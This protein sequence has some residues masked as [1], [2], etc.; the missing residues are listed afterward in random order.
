[1]YPHE[2][3]LVK[4]M[5]NQ[6]FA[7]I[8]VNSDSKDRALEAMERENITW[9]SFFNGG[10]T[11]GPISG[12]WGVRSWPTIYVMDQRGVI[13][14]KNVR[15]E[16][17]TEA[18]EELVKEA[19]AALVDDLKSDQPAVR[20]IAAF[21][22]GKYNLPNALA[23]IKPLLKD[24]DPQVQQ[25][26]AVGLVL[27]QQSADDLRPLIRKAV[28]DTDTEVRLAALETLATMKDAQA[29]KLA[30]K[31]LE[32]PQITVRRTAVL[33]LGKI[34]DPAAVPALAKAVDDTDVITARNAAYA[35]A[36]I[37]STESIELLNELAGVA[38]HPSRVWIAVALHRAGQPGSA[39]RL[40]KLMADSDAKIRRQV[41]TI[42]PDL[43]DFD[44]T[45]LMI[46]AL[47]DEDPQVGKKAR[48]YLAQSASP[49]AQKALKDYLVKRVD[50][51]I[52][53][54]ADRD[55][56]KQ[57]KARTELS[58]I[59]PEAAPILFEKL[60]GDLSPNVSYLLG[61]LIGASGN[62]GVLA[63]TTKKLLDPSLKPT[64]RSTYESILRGLGSK[65]R[66]SVKQL[67]AS[68]NSTIRLSGIRTLLTA[69][70]SDAETM[71]KSALKDPDTQVRCY[72][73]YALAMRR[74][75]EA[76]PVLKELAAQE[77]AAQLQMVAYGLSYYGEDTALPLLIKLLASDQP[78]VRAAALMGMGRFTS[79]KATAAIVEAAA[80]NPAVR[81]QAMSALYRQNTTQ[82]AQALGEYL[83]NEDPKVCQQAIQWLNRMRIPEAKLIVNKYNQ[84]QQQKKD[85]DKK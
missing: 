19:R 47:S 84:E 64:Q 77:N 51:L 80:E 49:R 17:M 43:S 52:P 75:P 4:S 15:G 42:L 20:G 76:L 69:R 24:K 70:D 83:K 31:A 48:A 9:P 67:L 58:A 21:R 38:D 32:D 59:G 30:A 46:A 57:R 1:M 7:L 71:L 68:D 35:L 40:Q 11:R 78:S 23:A 29:S 33:M 56:N 60:Q 16:A 62:L 82:A 61:S 73:A 41:V 45:D 34:G 66:E 25:R 50:A 37:K 13:R 72:A 12:A 81:I 53:A 22:M 39:K 54:L 5:A 3:S 85:D 2:R 36:D 8:G 10:S 27:L 26:A 65:A 44:P 63:P 55:Y 79:A 6:P 14:F 18:V 28:A 74:D